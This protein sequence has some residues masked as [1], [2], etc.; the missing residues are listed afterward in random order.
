MVEGE[1]GDAG[2]NGQDDEV[3]GQ[4]VAAAE[5]GDVEEHDGEE[6]AG[7]G[8]DKGQVIDVREGGV[9]ER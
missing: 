9:A 1:D 2:R 6:L 7:F 4:R 3:L 5:E 8:E